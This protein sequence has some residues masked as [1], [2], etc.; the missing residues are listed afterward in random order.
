MNDTRPRCDYEGS[1]YQ[2]EFWTPD[3]TYEDRVE[4]IALRKLLPP[5]GRRLIEIGAGAGR[6]ASLY[7]GY[8]EVYL[9]DYARSQL[10]Q[11]AERLGHDPRIR[12]VQGDIYNLPFPTGFFDTVVTVRVLHHVVDL[13]AAFEEIARILAPNGVYVTEYANKRNL[14]A[15][16]RWLL[17]R[18]RPGENPFSLDP[19]EFVPLNL[20]YHPAMVDWELRI[21]GF[22]HHGELSASFFRMPLL[23]RLLPTGL[24]V[25]LDARL[26]RPL[27]PLRLTPS[28]FVRAR[29]I[30][31][32]TIAPETAQWRCPAC[33]SLDMHEEEAGLACRA[34][35]R[36]YPK[37]NG[38]YVLR[39][40][41][42]EEVAS[43]S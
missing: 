30:R 41:L 7:E 9:L 18:A 29:L 36:F 13:G 39:A 26:Q 15:I 12:Y 17:R 25:A 37:T 43:R 35:G 20:D 22:T 2:D 38:V 8:D 4:R 40:D 24:L 1:R 31:Q 10:E 19:Y 3:R 11:A 42:V 16:L 32:Q 21:A 5:R 27:A 6:L 28:I 34:C 23:K 33:H 14:K